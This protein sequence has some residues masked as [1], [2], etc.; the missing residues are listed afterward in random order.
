MPG[1]P[2]GDRGNWNKE[3]RDRRYACLGEIKFRTF[4]KRVVPQILL[5]EGVD[6][7]GTNEHY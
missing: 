2:C 7:F 1:V 4:P 3:S 6:Y 5:L